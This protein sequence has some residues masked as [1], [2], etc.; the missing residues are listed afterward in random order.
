VIGGLLFLRFSFNEPEH[1]AARAA[2]DRRG[3]TDV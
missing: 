1:R 2:L 3:R